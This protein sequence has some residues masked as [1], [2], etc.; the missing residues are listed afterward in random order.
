MERGLLGAII[1]AWCP[2]RLLRAAGPI[3]PFSSKNTKVLPSQICSGQPDRK[4][5]ICL[6][7]KMTRHQKYKVHNS[8]EQEKTSTSSKLIPCPTQDGYRNF[9]LYQQ[10]EKHNLSSH[11]IS[12]YNLSNQYIFTEH[13]IGF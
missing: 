11:K 5:L 1:C 8:L 6:G 9:F 2:T 13:Y 4:E 3:A 7:A 12:C 10:K